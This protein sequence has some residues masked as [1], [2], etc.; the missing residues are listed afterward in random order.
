MANRLVDKEIAKFDDA[1]RVRVAIEDSDG[2]TM[3][4][5]TRGHQEVEIASQITPPFVNH[6]YKL[7]D[8]WTDTTAEAVVESSIISVTDATAAV[9]GGSIIV[10]DVVNARFYTGHVLAINTLD[11]TVD[12][13]I[14]YPYASGSDVA[15]ASHDMNV[16]GT[17]ANPVVFGIRLAEPPASPQTTIELDITRVLHTMITTDLGDLADFG[18]IEGGITNGIV[19]RKKYSNGTFGNILNLKT[20]GDFALVAYD[21]DRFIAGNP[22]IGVNGQK[23]RLTFGSEG[24]MGTVIRVGPLEDLQWVVQDD[25]TTILSY[26]NMAE[27]ALVAD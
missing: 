25:L 26:L 4:F 10:S 11:I 21:F 23:W 6:F 7:N 20:N 14:D 9:V 19:L 16:L 24:K 18:D 3:Q 8:G 5:N 2:Q 12:K 13:P 17:L 22:G 27:G 1:D 15:F